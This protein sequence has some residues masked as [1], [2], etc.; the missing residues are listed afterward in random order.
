[1]LESQ[2][3]FKTNHTTVRKMKMNCAEVMQLLLIR[4]PQCLIRFCFCQGNN[5]EELRHHRPPVNRQEFLFCTRLNS[6]NLLTPKTYLMLA[7]FKKCH[8][9]Q[10]T[11]S[12]RPLPSGGGEEELQDDAQCWHPAGGTTNAS[13][14][15]AMNVRLS[16]S[17]PAF[18]PGFILPKSANCSVFLLMMMFLFE[19]RFLSGGN[20]FIGHKLAEF[21]V[22]LQYV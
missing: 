16:W 20:V 21:Y 11:K 9:V 3:V 22:H 10:V 2:E 14:P 19:I 18:V 7:R 6:S 15:S 1:M 12:M 8:R 13:S 17:A 5:Q 4:Q